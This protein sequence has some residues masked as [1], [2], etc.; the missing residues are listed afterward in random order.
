MKDESSL[1]QQLGGRKNI[2]DR[3]QTTAWFAY[4]LQSMGI[5]EG[6]E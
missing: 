1:R 4:L 6:K 2:E 5:S 3:V